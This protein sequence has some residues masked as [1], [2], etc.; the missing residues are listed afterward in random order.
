MEATLMSLV[1]PL[2]TSALIVVVFMSAAWVAG[3]IRKDNSSVD[4]AWGIGI[5]LIAASVYFNHAEGYSRQI[6]SVLLVIIWGTRLSVHIAVRNAGK[7]EDA[8]Y[9]A[10]RKQWKPNWLLQSYLKI[11]MLQGALQLVIVLPVILAAV[12]S[13]PGFYII[14]TL[15]FLLW[16]A[17]FFI[18][19][20]SD[21]QLLLHK[22]RHPKELLTSEF[23]RYSRHPNYFGEAVQWWGIFLITV[24]SPFWIIGLISPLT[25]TWLLIRVSGVR[26]TEKQLKGRQGHSSYVKNTSAFIPWFPRGSRPGT[27][28]ILTLSAAIIVSLFC[29]LPYLTPLPQTADIP[30]GTR[31]RTGSILSAE[32]Y[33]T[34]YDAQGDPSHPAIV[35]LHGFGGTIDDWQQTV[36]SLVEAGY[37]VIVPELK[38]FGQSEKVLDQDYTHAAQAAHVFAL[39]DKL[40][41][42][43]AVVTGH[44]MGANIAV[45]MAQV[46]PSRVSRLVL[47]DAALVESAPFPQLSHLAGVPVVRDWIRHA[48][49]NSISPASAGGI[50]RSAV[51]DARTVTPEME[52][53]YGAALTG[54]WDLALIG[55][56]RDSGNNTLPLPLKDTPAAVSVIWGA[57]DPWIPFSE[58]EHICRQTGCTP[59]VTGIQNSGHLPMLEQP[60]LF[61]RKLLDLI[62]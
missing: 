53:S 36:P 23:W 11:Y 48:L 40:G 42:Q 12:Y 49:R 21:L 38:G 31:I 35:L 10:F 41:V 24:G 7:G 6:M 62:T 61:N 39:M 4:I 18:E 14:N 46:N 22:W 59:G 20:G 8:R 34:Y 32:G 1:I 9:A 26:M 13:G 19:S 17:G 5:I 29:I 51:S 54:D 56:I 60:A 27:A 16:T 30:A 50:L 3:I 44:S 52:K 37:F 2:M 58:G 57:E 45:T 28:R 15:G 55:I 43:H 47:V 33:R 25:L